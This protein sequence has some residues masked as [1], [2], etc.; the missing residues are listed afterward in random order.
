MEWL[1]F[2]LFCFIATRESGTSVE[3][4]DYLSYSSSDSETLSDDALVKA[5]FA[6]SLSAASMPV[7][8]DV[9]DGRPK[10]L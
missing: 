3:A 4:G 1:P 6:E 9:T 7:V 8:L 10:D 5:A 2:L